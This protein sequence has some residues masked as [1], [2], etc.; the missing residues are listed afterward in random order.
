MDPVISLPPGNLN[1]LTIDQSQVR[2][3]LNQLGV[4]KSTGYINIGNLRLKSSHETLS[5]SVTS[6][7]EAWLNKGNFPDTWKT[8]QVAPIFK[9]GNKADASFY[10]PSLLCCCSE[11]LVKTI[12]DAIYKHTKVTL[13][14]N[15]LGFQNRRPASI[16][17]LFLNQ[18]YDHYDKL[19]KEQLKVLYFDFSKAF[20]TVPHNSVLQKIRK[21]GT[22][23]KL[24]SKV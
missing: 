14:K 13:H 2:K 24:L 17:L 16:Q 7:F 12:F 10:R 9:E 15:Q 11:V 20:D 4:I 5:K 1:P 21:F 19:D 18:I 8:C 22:G 23:G 6:I 3:F